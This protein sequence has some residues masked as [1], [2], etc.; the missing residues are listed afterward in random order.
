MLTQLG[1]CSKAKNSRQLRQLSLQELA[2]RRELTAGSCPGDHQLVIA[3]VPLRDTPLCKC[4]IYR[5]PEINSAQAIQ[6]AYGSGGRMMCLKIEEVDN[7]PRRTCYDI[8]PD[9]P[10]RGDQDGGGLNYGG[11]SSDQFRCLHAHPM[12]G[13]DPRRGFLSTV[14]AIQQKADEDKAAAEAA[15]AEASTDRAELEAAASANLAA[16]EAAA[17]GNL[18]DQAYASQAAASGNLT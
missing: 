2:S 3:D 7:Q 4:Q 11:C 17:S 15:L 10:V 16:A 9:Y 6:N 1:V 8:H 18:A 5:Q 14:K 13:L 12:S